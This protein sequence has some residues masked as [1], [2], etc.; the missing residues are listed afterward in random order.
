MEN[1]VTET[2]AVTENYMKRKNPPP[3]TYFFW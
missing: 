2:A 1:F 3:K